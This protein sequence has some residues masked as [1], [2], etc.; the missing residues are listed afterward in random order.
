MYGIETTRWLNEK[1]ALASPKPVAPSETGHLFTTAESKSGLL[2]A[3]STPNTNPQT[4]D[5]E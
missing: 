1:A 3:L 5:W 2:K 4:R